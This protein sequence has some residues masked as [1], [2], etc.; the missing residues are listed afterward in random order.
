MY[1]CNFKKKKKRKEKK[2]NFLRAITGCRTVLKSNFSYDG[3]KVKV[4]L[5]GLVFFDRR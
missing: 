5:A 3:G 1:W 4:K 2:S